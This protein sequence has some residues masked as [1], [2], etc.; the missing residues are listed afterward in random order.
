[1]TT[2]DIAKLEPKPSDWFSPVVE[3]RGDGVARFSNPKGQVKGPLLARFDESSIAI[4]MEGETAEAEGIGADPFQLLPLDR[5]N[6]CQSLEV[7]T[8]EGVLTATGPIQPG[9]TIGKGL[10][11]RF[12]A[13]VSYFVTANPN[14]SKYW[15]LPLTNLLSDFMP[16]HAALDQHPLRI[17]PTPD[18]PEHLKDDALAT[19]IALQKNR[20]IVFEFAD[21]LGF[22]EPL[23]DYKAREEDLLERRKHCAIT[24]VMVGE[25]NDQPTEHFEDV[26]KWFPFNF[27]DLLGLATGAEVGAPW[28]EFRD[29]Q[30][31]LVRRMHVHLSTPVYAK[32]HRAI[33]EVAHR[34]TG[35]L[36][37]NASSCQYWSTSCLRVA[38]RQVVRGGRYE[39]IILEDRFSYLCRAVET[40]CNYHGISTYNLL[41]SLEPSVRNQVQ[42]ELKNTATRIDA[43]ARAQAT[44]GNHRQARILDR[45]GERTVSTPTGQDRS[46]ALQIRDLLKLYSLPDADIIDSHYQ[47]HPRADGRKT[48][49]SVL[50]YYRGAVTHEGY[51]DTTGGSHDVED[52]WRITRHLHDVLIRILLKMANYDGTY[53]PTIST[54]VIQKPV[55]WVTPATQPSELGYN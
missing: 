23:P 16:S 55:D 8:Q 4:E 34:G 49:G 33:R 39:H 38:L 17:Y 37:T 12:H 47:N 29:E 15:V 40:L 44:A 13:D 52:V 35:R 9:F 27:L 7:V 43:I 30:G 51:Y 25:V 53:S 50:S 10:Q 28:I 46:F 3:Y 54:W 5:T 21:S 18:I 36:L 20:L 48:W 1:M 26:Q 14:K 2:E 19:A 31:D 32:G 45:I 41:Q 6:P 42:A 24:A 11:L 22:I